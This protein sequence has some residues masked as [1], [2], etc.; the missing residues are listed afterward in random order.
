[1]PCGLDLLSR[2][3]LLSGSSWGREAFKAP[4]V[5]ARAPAPEGLLVPP[6]AQR[7]CAG[8]HASASS[9]VQGSLD[10]GG[11][12]CPHVLAR[13]GRGAV[14]ALWATD[15]W[16]RGGRTTCKLRDTRQRGTRVPES[17]GHVHQTGHRT[18]FL[19]PLQPPR[20]TWRLNSTVQ[21]TCGR[22]SGRGSRAGSSRTSWGRVGV[23]TSPPTSVDGLACV[24]TAG[25]GHL[26]GSLQL[27][28]PQWSCWAL[29]V[30]Q[31]I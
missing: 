7:V 11:V 15:T 16:G 19:P 18:G 5:L 24:F 22:G 10:G 3:G 26:P 9:S 29:P 30:C 4:C 21:S 6:P 13:A 12:H 23:T 1:M 31:A 17:D 20:Q 14:P 28:E 8:S 27:S 25:R 2:P